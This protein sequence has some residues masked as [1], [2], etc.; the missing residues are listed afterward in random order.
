MAYIEFS[1]IPRLSRLHVAG[2]GFARPIIGRREQAEIQESPVGSRISDTD[3]LIEHSLAEVE[4]EHE[5]K[6]LSRIRVALDEERRQATRGN[7]RKEFGWET[8]KLGR[9][10]RVSLPE[11]SE[12]LG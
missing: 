8:L 12:D 2:A 7:R 9:S 3:E 1:D 10:A 4:Q 5:S 6:H 11:Q